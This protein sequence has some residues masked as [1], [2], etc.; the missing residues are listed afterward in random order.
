[1]RTSTQNAAVRFFK[2]V[3]FIAFI[4]FVLWLASLHGG[5]STVTPQRV[6][7]KDASYDG[8][9]QNSEEEHIEPPLPGLS[10]LFFLPSFLLTLTCHIHLQ[11]TTQL[12]LST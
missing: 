4:I 10:L 2:A 9:Q 12:I 3:F 6:E 5:C 11:I 8:N 1:M 7:S